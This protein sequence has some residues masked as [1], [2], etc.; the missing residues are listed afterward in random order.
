MLI[1][2]SVQ[3]ENT[4]F[5]LDFD[6]QSWEC[7]RRSLVRLT[8]ADE[9]DTDREIQTRRVYERSECAVL[10]LNFV[11]K[12][13]LGG[14]NFCPAYAGRNGFPLKRARGTQIEVSP[15]AEVAACT[16]SAFLPLCCSGVVRLARILCG[17]MARYPDPDG[18]CNF[19]GA[20]MKNC[21]PVVRLQ[22][23]SEYKESRPARD[24][25]ILS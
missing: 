23:L 9:R 5:K 13:I 17:V 11:P 4:D 3:N 16:E 15:I 10:G 12:G 7:F 6:F 20:D 2:F 22:I 24:Q 21:R 18:S 25:R 19:Q 8:C 14:R 1:A